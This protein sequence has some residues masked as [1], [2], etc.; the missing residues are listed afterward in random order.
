MLLPAGQI[1]GYRGHLP[2]GVHVLLS[3]ALAVISDEPASCVKRLDAS[4]GPLVVPLPS[5]L[6]LPADATLSIVEDADVLYF[7]RHV[8]LAEKDLS[9]A[10]EAIGTAAAP[11]R[12]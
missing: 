12:S 2:Q 11:G 5:Q 4:H 8:V 9:R 7:A 1:L 3:G 6:E 10:L